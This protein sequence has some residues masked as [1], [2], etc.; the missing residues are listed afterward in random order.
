MQNI[1]SHWIG[2]TAV[3]ILEGREKVSE[4]ESQTSRDSP[5]WKSEKTNTGKMMNRALATC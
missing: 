5:I 4:I 1:K 2:I 3:W